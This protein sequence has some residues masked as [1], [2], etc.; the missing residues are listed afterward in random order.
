[1]ATTEVKADAVMTSTDS[2]RLK[3]LALGESPPG[4]PTTCGR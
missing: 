4:H 2:H 3:P 1:M